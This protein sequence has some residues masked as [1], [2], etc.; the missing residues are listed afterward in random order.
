MDKTIASALVDRLMH[1]AHLVATEGTQT[2]LARQRPRA[3]RTFWE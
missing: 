3:A 2:V 1:D